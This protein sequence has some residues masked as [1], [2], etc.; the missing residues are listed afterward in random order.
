MEKTKKSGAMQ[1]FYKKLIAVV[2][3]AVVLMVGLTVTALTLARTSQQLHQPEEIAVEEMISLSPT[4]GGANTLVNITGMG[5]P[6]N[7]RVALYLS[8]AD[9]AP[10]GTSNGEALTDAEGMFSVMFQMPAVWP[11]G[12]PI[13]QENLVITASATQTLE[14][15]TVEE[16]RATAS[17]RYIVVIQ[18]EISISPST[19][20]AGATTTITSTG[21]PA[22]TPVNI[23]IG[24]R[25]GS[26]QSSQVYATGMTD[27]SGIVT[28]ALALPEF[29]PD[30][31]RIRDEQLEIAAVTAD[32]SVRASVG[33]DYIPVPH[34]LLSVSPN[35]GGPDTPV[36]ITGDGFPAGATVYIKLGTSVQDA[37]GREAYVQVR[38]DLQGNIAIPFTMPGYWPGGMPILV[39]DVVVLGTTGDGRGYGW[40]GFAYL[41]HVAQIVEQVFGTE[42][43]P[44]ATP[45]SGS[46]SDD[47]AAA[48]PVTGEPATTD[49]P[50]VVLNP[51]IALSPSAGPEGTRVSISGSGFPADTQLSI[52]FGLPATGLDAM[53]YAT[54]ATDATGAFQTEFIMPGKWSDGAPI[55]ESNLVI[56]V[57][58]SDGSAQA[59]AD[60]LLA[61]VT[62][63]TDP[64]EEP[65][66]VDTCSDISVLAVL[67]GIAP[68][69]YVT[70]PASIAD[71]ASG[72]LYDG[73]RIS[74]V[75]TG[76]IAP[77]EAIRSAL[78]LAG[79][80]EDAASPT[81]NSAVFRLGGNLVVI[82]VGDGV[83]P[84][85]NEDGSCTTDLTFSVMVETAHIAG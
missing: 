79:W 19:G 42:A 58:N 53:E 41:N 78:S 83:C 15:G 9:A 2:A 28:L 12:A 13:T 22:N 56:L 76:Q 72:S 26:R 49:A 74:F 69:G 47:P 55:V 14:D 62:P 1:P 20:G 31:A 5:F 38:A 34:P 7:A 68:G 6:A 82:M 61:V 48:A 11:D 3:A 33:F 32:G 50:T 39:R 29:W 60:F 24:T 57:T 23:I 37:A 43:T 63:V 46:G 40:M 59:A 17:F 71:P 51:A 4:Y 75:V 18:P 80:A 30:G 21:F 54:A 16:M 81:P 77:L 44:E 66:V 64:T 36:T 85:P 27:A 73:C 35:Y 67:A 65:V 84:T 45:L 52:R 25:D 8:P 10:G 70:E